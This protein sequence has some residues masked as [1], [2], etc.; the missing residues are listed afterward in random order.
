[1]RAFFCY[2]M[3]DVC[4]VCVLLLHVCVC[5]RRLVAG[6]DNAPVSTSNTLKMKIKKGFSH[7]LCVVRML[8]I[9]VS[10]MV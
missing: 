2:I 4:S 10:Y 5:V 6:T 7:W 9:D 1:M 8:S 3:R